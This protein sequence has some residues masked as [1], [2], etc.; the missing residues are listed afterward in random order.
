MNKKGILIFSC[1]LAFYLPIAHAQ[2]NSKEINGGFGLN[3][4][5]KY[6]VNNIKSAEVLPKYGLLFD[7]TVPKP[8]KK[9]FD[10]Y[11]VLAEGETLKIFSITGIRSYTSGLKCEKAKIKYSDI[12]AKEYSIKPSTDNNKIFFSKDDSHI[13]VFCKESILMANYINSNS[14]K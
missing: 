7:S 3:F 9:Y 14:L 6:D 11:K 12:I 5:E 1:V 2:N 4:G 13:I 10:S 8:R